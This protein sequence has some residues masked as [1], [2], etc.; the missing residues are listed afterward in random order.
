MH[1]SA[2][3]QRI[4]AEIAAW[5]RKIK[6]AER[7]GHHRMYDLLLI[8][9]LPEPSLTV[10]WLPWKT[11]GGPGAVQYE[12]LLGTQSPLGLRNYV[13]VA[14]VRLPD[15]TDSTAGA[16]GGCDE[17][18]RRT[19][20]EAAHVVEGIEVPDLQ[21]HRVDI[22]QRINHPGEV[23]RAKT[24]PLS[25]NLVATKSNLE[26][27]QV[28]DWPS[29]P[30][31]PPV[32]G[33]A[34]PD[35]RLRG[36]RAE[37]WGLDWSPLQ[38]GL[39]LSGSNDGRMCYWDIT[40]SS[41]DLEPLRTYGRPHGGRAVSDVA[42]HPS[43]CSI[44]ASVGHDGTLCAWDTRSAGDTP[45]DSAC[46]AHKG[47]ALCLRFSPNR[48]AL[49]ATGGSDKN[50]NIF[51][52]RRFS[53]P[54]HSLQYHQEAVFCIEWSSISDASLLASSGADRKVAI[55]DLSCIGTKVTGEVTTMLSK[56]PPPELRFVH[57]GHTAPVTA[58]SW[59]PS[60]EG[61]ML[62]SVDQSGA[63][64]IWQVSEEVDAE[65]QKITH[66]VT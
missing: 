47:E 39:V 15:V 53:K 28:F 49:L 55:W 44:L 12:L 8:E 40:A 45:A 61:L 51:D 64:H 14:G 23:L 58:V 33:V 5:E 65:Y 37:G 46:G 6:R 18:L 30:A 10:Q 63:L 66:L 17:S 1:L 20:L 9:E 7:N 62:A 16:C 22:Q 38:N 4:A 29:Q 35:V 41:R 60:D 52:M 27:V 26:E 11:H 54:L 32:K 25:P 56:H 3:Q 34:Q 21:N 19:P 57:A 31:E 50:I 59:S 42:C 2:K 48:G 43:N 24:N 36:H 13:K